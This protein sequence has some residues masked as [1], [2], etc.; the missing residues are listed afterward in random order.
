MRPVRPVRPVRL[1]GRLGDEAVRASSVE[2][3]RG[4]ASPCLRA[5]IA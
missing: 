5:E 1:G 4:T 2:R 3:R